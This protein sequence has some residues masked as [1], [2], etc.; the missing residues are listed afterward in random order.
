MRG[1]S[2][3]E[4]TLVVGLLGLLTALVIPV[5]I[6]FYQTSVLDDATETAVMVLRRAQRQ[7]ASEKNNS[8]FGVRFLPESIVLFQGGTYDTR[9][10]SQDEIFNIPD[11]IGFSGLSE[12]DFWAI[13]G[14]TAN[15]GNVIVNSGFFSRTIVVNNQGLSY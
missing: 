8:G 12:I 11:T 13:T 10:V 9:D 1:F 3:L 4:V 6:R 14:Q 5:G 2:I 7:A 15:A